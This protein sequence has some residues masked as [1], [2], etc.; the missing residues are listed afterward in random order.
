MFLDGRKLAFHVENFEK[1]EQAFTVDTNR[2]DVAIAG[3]VA[4][5]ILAG[6]VG[7]VVNQAEL[8]GEAGECGYRV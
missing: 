5:D 6:G 7:Q 1:L 4:Q 3:Q 8:V 2:L